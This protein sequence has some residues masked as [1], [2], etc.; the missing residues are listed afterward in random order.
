[1]RGHEDHEVQLESVQNEADDQPADP[2]ASDWAPALLGVRAILCTTVRP[3]TVCRMAN[4][5]AELDEVFTAL[6]DA[7]RRSI[8]RRLGHGPTSVGVLASRSAM[9]LP[10]FMKHVRTLERCGLITTVKRGRVRTCMLRRDRLDA[11]GDW[12][13]EQRTLWEGRTDRLEALVTEEDR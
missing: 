8:V 5:S 10:S 13:A 1:M 12:L 4:C 2:P 9:T 6:G 7:T 3:A 11:V